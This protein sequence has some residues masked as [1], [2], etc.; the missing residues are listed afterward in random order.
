MPLGGD[1]FGGASNMEWGFI[2]VLLVLLI[3]NM[4]LS[5]RTFDKPSADDAAEVRK[6]SLA[7]AGATFLL[8]AAAVG[9]RWWSERS[10]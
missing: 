2:V 3:I 7:V 8:T 4:A 9:G 5:W 1:I 10:Q 6:G